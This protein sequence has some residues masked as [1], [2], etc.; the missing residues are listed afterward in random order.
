MTFSLCVVVFLL[1]FCHV[2]TCIIMNCNSVVIT[3]YLMLTVHIL[4][5][6]LGV[7]G[8]RPP[9]GGAMYCPAAGPA[10]SVWSET[11]REMT[12]HP[13]TQL[14]PSE[15]FLPVGPHSRSSC[16]AKNPAKALSIYF[17]I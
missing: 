12:K 16:P 5:K 15:G 2:C 1:L 7:G 10:A 13:E 3:F 9:L 4:F 8:Y 14:S 11:S 17:F 6:M